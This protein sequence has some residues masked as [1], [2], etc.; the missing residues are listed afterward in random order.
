MRFFLGKNRKQK[1]GEWSKKLWSLL[2]IL[3]LGMAMGCSNTSEDSGE[4]QVIELRLAHFFPST[5][6]AETDLIQPW[7]AAIEEATAGQVKIVSYPNQTLLNADSIY[8]GVVDG[9]TDLGLSCFSYTRGRFPVLEVFELPGISYMNSKVASQVAWEGIKEL[10]PHEIQDTKLLMV[11][12]TGPGDLYT[13]TAVRKLEDLKG[14]EIRATGL[15]ATTLQALGAVPSA[16]PQ[17]DAYEA[18][19]KGVVKGNLGPVEVLKGW[20]QAEVT[21]YI[22]QTPFLYNT[23]F[24]ITMNLDKWN[25]LDPSLQQAIEKVNEEYFEKVARSLWDKQNEDALQYAVDEQGMEVIT[26]AP[27]ESQR[28]INLVQPIQDDF[29]S[30]MNTQGYQGQEILETVKRLAEQYNQEYQ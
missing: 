14:M 30:R 20:K 29:V 19:T 23:L 28:W 5:H 25:S 10:N 1:I 6:P 15:S 7:I 3:I 22:T 24:F 9:S 13:R 2:L 21:D 17:S 4:K 16:M 12:T 26:L 18:L 27:E 11:F 8:A